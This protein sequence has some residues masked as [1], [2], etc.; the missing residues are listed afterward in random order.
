MYAEK[1]DALKTKMSDMISLAKEEQRS[2]TE[3]ELAVCADAKAEIERLRKSAEIESLSAEW[4]EEKKAEVRKARQ[5]KPE[6]EASDKDEREAMREYILRGQVEGTDAYGGYTVPTKIH[7]WIVAKRDAASYVRGLATVVNISG[8]TNIPVESTDLTA[9]WVG[10]GSSITEGTQSFASAAL[11]PRRL[12]ALDTIS[13]DLI[14]DSAFDLI[15]YLV[16]KIGGRIFPQAEETAFIKGASGSG[17]PNGI[18]SSGITVT[19]TAA[20]NAVTAAEIQGLFFDL[21]PEYQ[22]NAT[23]LI[24]GGLAAKLAGLTTGTGGIFAWG[25]N[26][27]DGAPATLMG[28]PC[29]VSKDLDDVT[30]NKTIAIV[31]DFSYY[32]IGDQGG[33][34]IQRLNELYAASGKVGLR[35]TERVGGVLTNTAAFKVL[36]TKTT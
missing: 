8:P 14:Q 26:L 11:T 1:I 32:F 30:T 2:L 36:G 35:F 23:W 12:C 22:K 3:E 24:S 5:I 20:N 31:G 4:D 25:G 16:E 27:A 9:Y 17:E 18:L 13:D 29:Y 19:R 6:A 21:G 10:E 34:Q 15:G 28:R 7:D 33:I